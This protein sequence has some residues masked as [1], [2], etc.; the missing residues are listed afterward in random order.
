[1]LSRFAPRQRR[2]IWTFGLLCAV[3]VAFMVMNGFVTG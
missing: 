1:M 2:A 3:A